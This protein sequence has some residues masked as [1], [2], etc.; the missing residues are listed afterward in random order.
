MESHNIEVIDFKK[1]LNSSKIIGTDATTE[2]CTRLC[3]IV[4]YLNVLE[5]NYPPN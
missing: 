4:R 3:I 5:G 2:T 1:L